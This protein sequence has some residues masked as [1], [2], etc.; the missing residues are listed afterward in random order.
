MDADL[1]RLGR[2]LGAEL[3]GI[4]TKAVASVPAKVANL[5]QFAPG[6]SV[7]RFSS[8]L[9]ETF[10]E[11]Y[12]SDGSSFAKASE[13]RVWEYGS[14]AIAPE[15]DLLPMIGK[16]SSEQWTLGHT[17]RFAVGALEVVKGRVV[18]R[19]GTIWFQDWLDD[20]C[21]SGLRR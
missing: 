15:E 2:Y 19:P 7:E 10:R 3:A 16:I 5:S 18:N 6:V 17:P 20:S 21:A 13:G 4:E 8:A 12:G 9:V 11:M 14:D 1:A